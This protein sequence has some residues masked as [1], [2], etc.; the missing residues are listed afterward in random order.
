MNKDVFNAA[1]AACQG[2]VGTHREQKIALI[3]EQFKLTRDEA[4]VCVNAWES[5]REGRDKLEK[6]FRVGRYPAGCGVFTADDRLIFTVAFREK[7]NEYPM[8]FIPDQVGEARA[9]K[10]CKLMN[11][12]WED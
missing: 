7:M 4:E 5:G 12:H 9:H 2:S 11:E 10:L 3:T 1:V 6:P 8:G